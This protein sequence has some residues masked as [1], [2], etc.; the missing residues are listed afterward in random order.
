MKKQI[1]ACSVLII[2]FYALAF[3]QDSGDKEA[4]KKIGAQVRIDSVSFNEAI[5]LF[6]IVT[7]GRVIYATKDG[8]YM[9]LGNVIEVQTLKNL[10]TERMASLR[11]V[12]F[13]SLK[14]DDAIKISDGK[15]AIAVFED[16]DCQYC[17]NL[18][19]E[20]KKLKDVSIY[21]FL[22]PFGSP[23]KSESIWCSPDRVSALE[24]GFSGATINK[25]QKCETPIDRI[26]DFALKHEFTG[27]PTVIFDNNKSF[28]GFMAADMIM[29]LLAE[30]PRAK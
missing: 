6:E 21:I 20:L 28:P 14:L 10:T 3:G 4:L 23:E 27:I 30:A 17:K 26:K 12:D 7:N 29:N 24:K 5:G 2:I 13:S 9:I 22:Y 11:T 25:T 16:P 15:R 8:K 19:V 18:N 1:I